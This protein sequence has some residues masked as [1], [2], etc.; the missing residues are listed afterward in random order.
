M[1]GWLEHPL[2][3]WFLPVPMLA[4]VLPLI[5]LFFRGSWKTLEAEALDLRRALAAEG[6]V[7]Y[8]PLVTLTLG[9]VILTMQEYYGQLSFY[10]QKLEPF[11]ARVAHADPI[12]SCGRLW[13]CTPS[14][15][16]V[17]GGG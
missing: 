12:R 11:I 15:A 6:R 13:R 4:A 10:H 17:C 3:K 8:R 2:S 14:C 9:A 5:Y 1:I 7:D 16:G